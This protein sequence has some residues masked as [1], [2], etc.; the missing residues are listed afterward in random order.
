MTE[1]SGLESQYDAFLFA[2][3]SE[4]DEVTLSVLS[5]LARQD[6]DPWQEAAR[7]TRLPKDQAINNLA[8]KIWKSNSERW[9]PS[10]ASIVA[11]RLI[12]LLPSHSHVHSS[13]LWAGDNTGRLTFW[14]VTW[15]LFMSV[16]ISGHNIQKS[17]SDS[18]ALAS[19]VSAAAQEHAV[20]GSSR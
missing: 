10:E 8:A 2:S 7:L 15:M 11:A 12:E 14:M 18:R 16:A 6:V 1:F 9:S 19:S 17:T 3:L 13:P 4:T 20:T 5:L